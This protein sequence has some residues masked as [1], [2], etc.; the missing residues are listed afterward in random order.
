MTIKELRDRLN[1]LVE[2]GY[3]ELPVVHIMGREI[4]YVSMHAQ[5]ITQL[6]KPD[7]ENVDCCVLG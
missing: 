6:G 1:A 5:I 2:Q 3:G 7:K 4:D